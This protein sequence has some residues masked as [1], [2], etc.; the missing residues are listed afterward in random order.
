MTGPSMS[1]KVWASLLDPDG[2]EN[3]W[4][5]WESWSQDIQ[6][7]VILLMHGH[8]EAARTT[9]GVGRRCL[10]DPRVFGRKHG[11]RQKERLG[12]EGEK[13]ER[14][15][16]MVDEGE[17]EAR[18]TKPRIER[19]VRGLVWQER[20]R[21]G[22]ANSSSGIYGSACC[23]C[24]RCYS[25]CWPCSVEWKGAKNGY[26]TRDCSGS[27]SSEPLDH[28]LANGIIEALEYGT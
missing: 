24:F 2:L 10:G 25:T 22:K 1:L 20:A 12:R 11:A 5:C 23:A 14:N 17:L 4:I 9:S 7:L 27:F 8:L 16:A 6:S 13:I 28:W 19:R 18:C 15:E 26:Q 3:G 21:Q